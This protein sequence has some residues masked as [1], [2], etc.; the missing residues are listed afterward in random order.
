MHCRNV[1]DVLS[2][3]LN[4]RNETR[5]VRSEYQLN[6]VIILQTHVIIG[7]EQTNVS[8]VGEGNWR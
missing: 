1:S 7:S 3:T 2:K 5:I 4:A 8:S 6:P